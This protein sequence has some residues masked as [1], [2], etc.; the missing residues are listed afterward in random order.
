MNK[1][2]ET[3]VKIMTIKIRSY[4]DEAGYSDD[5]LKICDFLIRINQTKVITPNYL[6]GRWVWQFGPYMSMKH[7]SK[8]GVV[9]DDGKIVG[10]A[11]YENDIGEAYFCI[12]KEYNYLKQQ[13]I[14]YAIKNLSLNGE[15]RIAL[16]DGDLVYQQ[17]AVQKGFI[18]SNQKSSVARIDIDRNAYILPEGFSIMSFAADDFDIDRYYDAIWKGFDNK[19]EPN[20]V[21]QESRKSDTIFNIPHFDPNLRILVIAPNGEY[22]AHCGMWHIPESE[23]A[24]VEPVFTLPKYRKMGLGKAAV[25]EGVNRCGKLGAKQAY[26]LSSQQFYYNIGFY[27]IQNETWWKYKNNS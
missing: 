17:V 18:P 14:D 6:W 3:R 24:Y 4:K 8:I 7:L 5:F 27:P 9:E 21:E 25:L 10:L 23:Y 26:V 19:R 11:T 15:I 12:D 20:E 1:I 22:A 16:P 2:N 13:L